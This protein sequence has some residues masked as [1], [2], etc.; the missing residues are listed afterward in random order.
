MRF[1]HRVH[2]KHHK[3]RKPAGIPLAPELPQKKQIRRHIQNARNHAIA[4]KHFDPSHVKIIVHVVFA[5]E[6]RPCL[7][8]AVIV[9]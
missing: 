9:V 8:H 5:G 1:H 3:K 7:N 6:R 2:R 4:V